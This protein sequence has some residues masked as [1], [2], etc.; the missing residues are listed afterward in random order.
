MKHSG[1]FYGHEEVRRQDRILNKEESLNL[2]E[3]GEYGFLATVSPDGQPYGIPLSYV[4]SG[5][6]IYFHAAPE[7]HKLENIRKNEKVSFSIVGKTNVME[8][9]FTTKYESVIVFG[10]AYIVEDEEEKIEALMELSRKYCLPALDKAPEY[11]NKSLHRTAIVKILI[12]KLT[13]K[14]K[15]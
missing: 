14:T 7:G 12:E 2:L 9:A 15:K 11:I 13:G 4:V 6:Y 10:K 1:D 5:N 8:H 3:N